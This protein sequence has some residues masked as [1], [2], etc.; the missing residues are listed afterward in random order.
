MEKEK[1]KLEKLSLSEGDI[2]IGTFI[3]EAEISEMEELST[4]LQ[5]TLEDSDYN[6]TVMVLN[7]GIEIET[8][9]EK[10]LESFGLKRLN[11]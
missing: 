8:L 2:V 9:S 1:Y 10:E 6:N 11:K 4:L 5:N 7:E 3:E